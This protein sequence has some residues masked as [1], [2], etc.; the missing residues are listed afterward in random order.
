MLRD[1][2]DELGAAVRGD[3]IT[4]A[5]EAFAVFKRTARISLGLVG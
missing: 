1:T 4:E 3:K 5:Q 2:Y